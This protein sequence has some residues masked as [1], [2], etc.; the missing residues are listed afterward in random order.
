MAIAVGAEQFEASVAE[1]LVLGAVR[2]EV[3]RFVGFEDRAFLGGAD[4]LVGLVVRE[5]VIVAAFVAGKTRRR[6]EVDHPDV[7]IDRVAP[8]TVGEVEGLIFIVGRG[9]IQG[10]PLPP[11]R[12]L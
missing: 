4:A 11:L 2:S 6:R 1:L 5:V 12:D 3:D 9:S 8:A 7:R 10:I